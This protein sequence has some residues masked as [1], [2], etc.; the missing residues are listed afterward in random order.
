MPIARVLLVRTVVVCMLE[1]DHA[2]LAAC[3]C[4]HRQQQVFPMAAEWGGLSLAT[5]LDH[6]LLEKRTEIGFIS[7]E[8]TASAVLQKTLEVSI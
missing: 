1:R 2:A 6:G 4:S 8:A 7:A 5:L 3:R